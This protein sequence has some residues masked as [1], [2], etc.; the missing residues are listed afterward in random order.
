M[1]RF[2]SPLK[3]LMWSTALLLAALVAGC[4]AAG[5]D[6]ADPSLLTAAGAGSG[7]GGQGRGP[8][9]VNLRTAG[10]F[11][12][13]AEE[14]ITNVALS[15]VTG[16]VG[17]TPAIGTLIALTC[18]EVKGLI[19]TISAAGP[20]GPCR[21]TNA[22][23]L[24]TA[25]S[26][27]ITAFFDAKGRAPDYVDLGAGNL[28]GRNLGPA[29]YNWSTPVVIPSNLTLTGGPNDVWI[30]QIWQPDESVVSLSVSSGVQIIL[31]GGA[32]PQNVYWVIGAAD[33]GPGSQFKGVI[34]ADFSIVMR[35]GASIDGR[36]LAGSAAN[37]DQNRVTQP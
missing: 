36:V 37:L 10:N 17:L 31:A 35:T 12:I 22:S 34:M 16:D 7:V 25:K 20:S 13:L 23:R 6:G 32:L 21:V 33:L 28:G 19:Y 3:P 4:G 24:N 1:N 26:D 15:D 18:P 14:A 9:P 27:G 30:F 29:T 2:G 8:D 5:G 11:A